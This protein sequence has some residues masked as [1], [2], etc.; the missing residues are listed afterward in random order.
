L[1]LEHAVNRKWILLTDPEDKMA[2]VKVCVKDKMCLNEKLEL[3]ANCF[4][5]L[6]LFENIH[7]CFGTWRQGSGRW[8]ILYEGGE[9][10]VFCILQ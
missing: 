6:G 1:F 8:K 5:L 7:V 9:P 10:I 3:K 2:G 4:I